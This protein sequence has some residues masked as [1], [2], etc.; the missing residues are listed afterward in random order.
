MNG[1]HAAGIIAISHQGL[2]QLKAEDDSV[3][4]LL[5]GLEHIGLEARYVTTGVS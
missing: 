3:A 4:N 2:F 5:E 1:I